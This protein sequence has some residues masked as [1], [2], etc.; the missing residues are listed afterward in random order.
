[1]GGGGGEGRPEGL[2]TPLFRGAVFQ[3]KKGP[4]QFV[5]GN[6]KAGEGR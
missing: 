1:V 5:K 2:G 3:G 6:K 4:S